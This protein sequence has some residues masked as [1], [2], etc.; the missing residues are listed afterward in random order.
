M[1]VGG[2]S[3]IRRRLTAVLSAGLLLAVLQGAPPVGADHDMTCHPPDDPPSS[4][5][6]G[7]GGGRG[8]GRTFD[9]F[10]DVYIDI[11][12][13]RSRDLRTS[14]ASDGSARTVGTVR[15]SD[16]DGRRRRTIVLKPT[17]TTARCGDTNDDG[18]IGLASIAVDLE[19]ERTGDRYH[20]LIV[21]DGAD[22][23]AG[24]A[25]G[26]ARLDDGDDEVGVEIVS[27]HLRGRAG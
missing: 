26:T 7:G 27:M 24:E 6:R 13:N 20:L 11:G 18:R 14:V 9:S 25:R 12:V 16:P 17:G 4:P 1:A 22:L 2:T 3:S 8:G 10:F 15:I 21:P 5:G 23:V 19:H